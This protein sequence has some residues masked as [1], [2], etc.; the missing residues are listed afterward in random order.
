MGRRERSESKTRFIV[1]LVLVAVAGTG[2]IL[3][4]LDV[5]GSFDMDRLYTKL[6]K[7]LARL[8]CYL[9]VG[10][11]IGQLIEAAGWAAKLARLVRPLTKRARMKEESGTVFVAGFVSGIVAN[12]MLM[13]FHDEE[14]ITRGELILTYLLNNGLPVFLVHFPTTFVIVYSLA[15]KAG[16]TY[17]VI[18]F[19]AACLR[20]GIALLLARISLRPPTDGQSASIVVEEAANPRTSTKILAAF[21]DRFIRLLMYSVPIYVLVFVLNEWGLFKWL[22]GAT[23]GIISGDAFPY[24]AAGMVIFALAAEFSSGM[25][26][27]G[28]LIEAET[29]TV[30]QA[31]ISLIVGTV[32]A[33]PVRAIRHQL[34]THAG[35]FSLA[36]GSELLVLSQT[37]RV[38]S[39]IAVL[40]PYILFW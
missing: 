34:P 12:T 4:L 17:M 1:P 16:L 23:A 6:A 25:A 32:A 2:L 36:L 8:V 33:A 21:R 40:I 29:L 9:A 18:T 38:V 22:R 3:G 39:L 10:L 7:P 14:R 24:D 28:A 35:I 27:A 11:L 37:F 15:G 5:V 31:A 13:R 19:C 30:K 26:T 20:S